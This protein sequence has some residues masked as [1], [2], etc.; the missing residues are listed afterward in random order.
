MLS[1]YGAG[2]GF[3]VGR[4]RNRGLEHLQRR[5]QAADLELQYQLQLADSEIHVVGE[6]VL[7]LVDDPHFQ[8]TAQAHLVVAAAVVQILAAAVGVVELVV[9]PAADTTHLTRHFA[10]L[11]AELQKLAAG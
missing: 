1:A 7:E 4:L 2:L 6:I 10:A 3:D 11:E 5:H 8:K 9:G